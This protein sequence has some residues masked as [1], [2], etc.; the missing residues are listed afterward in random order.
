MFKVGDIVQW[1][2]PNRPFKIVDDPAC[3][4]IVEIVNENYNNNDEE[5]LTY[6]I[7]EWFGGF[8]QPYYA[9]ML[10]KIS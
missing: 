6:Y 7:V 1:T 3:G 9:K 4:I 2:D 5:E 8:T 10:R